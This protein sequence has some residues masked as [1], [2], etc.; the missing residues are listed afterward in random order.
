LDF[1]WVHVLQNLSRQ[2]NLNIENKGNPHESTLRD[3]SISAASQPGDGRNAMHPAGSNRADSSETD[4]CRDAGSQRQKSTPMI[5]APIQGKTGMGV[6]L[7]SSDTPSASLC[8]QCGFQ[9]WHQRL[10]YRECLHCQYKDAPTPREILDDGLAH[11]RN[12]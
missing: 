5:S 7:P 2:K 9:S 10:T 11:G 1:A 4:F 12:A 3:F 6:F 8:P